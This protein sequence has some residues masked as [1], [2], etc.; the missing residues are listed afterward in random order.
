MAAMPFGPLPLRDDRGGGLGLLLERQT[1]RDLVLAQILGAAIR[2]APGVDEKALM[3][4]LASAQLAQVEWCSMLH[5]QLGC[6]DLLARVNDQARAA[7]LVDS[8]VEV[9]IAL[10]LLTSATIIE[11]IGRT[12]TTSTAAAETFARVLARARELHALGASALRT[13][14][15]SAANQEAAQSQVALWLHTS[16]ASLR[17]VGRRG[18][19]GRLHTRATAE[20]MRRYLDALEPTLTACR[21]RLPPHDAVA[22]G[23]ELPT[24]V[25]RQG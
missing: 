19:S 21:L 12:S 9:Q 18:H 22:V 11:L 8:W 20:L 15:A 25:L 13:A 14:C 16:L 5:E 10:V 6:G 17:S 7:P 24:G 4:E 2:Y 23:L 1:Q 3:S